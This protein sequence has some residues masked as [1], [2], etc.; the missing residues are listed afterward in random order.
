MKLAP[1]DK[2]GRYIKDGHKLRFR[3]KDEF[4]PEGFSEFERLVR[5]KQGGL[6]G[7]YCPEKQ[8]VITFLE[9][10]DGHIINDVE[11]IN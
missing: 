10:Y 3:I 6:L 8:K 9:K 11:I 1:R 7:Y 2:N 4:T 5:I